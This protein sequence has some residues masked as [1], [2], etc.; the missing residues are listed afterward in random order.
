[1]FATRRVPASL[2]EPPERNV[3]TFA[4]SSR[5][6]DF[7]QS[8]VSGGAGL[9]PDGPPSS[10]SRQ[11]LCVKIR[12]ISRALNTAYSLQIPVYFL[13]PASQRRVTQSRHDSGGSLT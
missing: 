10:E 4:N 8:C 7:R 1:M 12:G 13:D 6:D 9:A 3:W 11:D 2:D 5:S